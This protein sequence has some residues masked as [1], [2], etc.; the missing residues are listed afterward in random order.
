MAVPADEQVGWTF[1][2]AA[3][4][5][6][7]LPVLDTTLVMISRRRAGIPLM[8]GGRDHLTHRLF[9]RLGSPRTVALTLGCIQAVLGAVAIGVVELGQGS[10]IAAWSV[11]FVAAAA[12]VAMLETEGWAPVREHSPAPRCKVAGRQRRA[13]FRVGIVEGG[14][15]CVHRYLLRSQSVPVR[16]LRRVGLGAR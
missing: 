8:T 14:G 3:A 11:W 9:T 10:V 13:A 16:L 4:L 15:D 2:L 5:L 1:P 12:A 6:A 7:G